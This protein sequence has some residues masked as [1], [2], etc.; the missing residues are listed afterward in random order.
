[1]APDDGWSAPG[2][3]HAVAT[4]AAAVS[5]TTSI[6]PRRE[7]RLAVYPDIYGSLLVPHPPVPAHGAAAP[8]STPQDGGTTP[9]AILL[10]RR[11]RWCPGPASPIS[12]KQAAKL[13]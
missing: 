12:T 4:T 7:N 1:M 3:L 8:V 13:I 9:C 10:R 11:N 5:G 6:M 2:A